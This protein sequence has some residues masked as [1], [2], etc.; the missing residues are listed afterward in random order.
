MAGWAGLDMESASG[1]LVSLEFTISMIPHFRDIKV[2]LRTPERGP[3]R[4][5][6]HPQALLGLPITIRSGPL[7]GRDQ[8]SGFGNLLTDSCASQHSGPP[9]CVGLCGA[10]PQDRSRP[11]HRQPLLAAGTKQELRPNQTKAAF[12]KMETPMGLALVA[13]NSEN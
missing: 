13:K 5:F 9:G 7:L 4:P 12:G 6:E 11:P 2:C 10:V 3:L 1:P 8:D